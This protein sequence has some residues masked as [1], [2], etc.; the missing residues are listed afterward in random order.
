MSYIEVSNVMFRGQLRGATGQARF[1]LTA[2]AVNA[3]DTINIAGNQVTYNFF[4]R[5]SSIAV[6]QGGVMLSGNI[7]VPDNNAWIEIIAFGHG[8]SALQ[9]NGATRPNRNRRGPSFELLPF[10]EIIPLAKGVHNVRLISG[11]TGT[12]VKGYIF[13]RY[14]RNTGLA[15]T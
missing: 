13:C 14:I 15:N 3:V 5:Y 1:K 6:A 4:F 7:N 2:K 9:V 8:A 12:S 11:F 10:V